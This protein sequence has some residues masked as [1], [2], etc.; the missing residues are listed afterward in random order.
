MNCEDIRK[1]LLE[2]ADTADLTAEQRRHVESCGGCARVVKLDA[3]FRE[4][5]HQAMHQHLT[6]PPHLLPKIRAKLAEPVREPFLRRLFHAGLRLSVMG[7]YG[8][9]VLAVAFQAFVETEPDL[10]PSYRALVEHAEKH[11][12]GLEE[13][14]MLRTSSYRVARRYLDRHGITAPLMKLEKA[15]LVGVKVCDVGNRKA[16]HL[17][18]QRGGRQI[19]SFVLAEPQR[20]EGL[21]FK[22]ETAGVSIVCHATKDGLCII[23]GRMQLAELE[24]YVPAD[25][26]MIL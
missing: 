18:Y 19:H 15:A 10:P 4:R 1:R 2:I 13:E 3:S 7:A 12:P 26:A 5:F 8:L 16:A 23:T 20:H 17:F 11:W 9:L 6:A 25:P 14:G 24:S 21:L 22:K